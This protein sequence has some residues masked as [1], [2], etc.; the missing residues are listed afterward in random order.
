LNDGRRG[1]DRTPDLGLV[2]AV[3]SQLSYP[4]VSVDREWDSIAVAPAVPEIV[5]QAAQASGGQLKVHALKNE[6]LEL[7]LA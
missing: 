5:Q 4:P 2:R 6:P 7:N 1:E 3:L